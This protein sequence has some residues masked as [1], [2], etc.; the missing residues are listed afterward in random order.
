MEEDDIFVQR[1]ED[2]ENGFH[3]NGYEEKWPKPKGS[4]NIYIYIYIEGDEWRKVEK[5]RKVIF[6]R[7]NGSV[8]KK[9]QVEKGGE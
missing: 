9:N 5:L 7:G 2:F 3:K 1:K 4:E 6:W 8:K